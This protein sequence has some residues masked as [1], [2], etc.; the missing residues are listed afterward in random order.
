MPDLALKYGCNPHQG[1]ARL[2]FSGS[3]L[4]LQ[5]LN[6]DP[7]YINILDALTAWPLVRELQASTGKT[8]AAS[9]KHLSPAG[10]AVEG[11]VT[12]DFARAQFLEG[13]PSS[14]VARA[15]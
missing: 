9:F 8:T 3:T 10:A 15:C 14:S 5:V 12:N 1:H 11:P 13:P 6:G 7:S 2:R 4:P